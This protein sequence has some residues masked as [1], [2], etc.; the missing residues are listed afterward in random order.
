MSSYL[1]LLLQMDYYITHQVFLSSRAIYIVVLDV[2]KALGETIETYKGQ[3]GQVEFDETFKATV[4][5]NIV[6]SDIYI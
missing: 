2:T 5:G 6:N 3:P 4:A 1:L